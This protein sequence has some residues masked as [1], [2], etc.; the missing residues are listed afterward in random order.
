MAADWPGYTHCHSRAVV[1]SSVLRAHGP[2]TNWLPGYGQHV[3][4]TLIQ[5]PLLKSI[6]LL[7]AAKEEFVVKLGW[8]VHPILVS[9]H[10]RHAPKARSNLLVHLMQVL[11][12]YNASNFILMMYLR[13]S[14]MSCS[15]Q[16]LHCQAILA[17]PN[18]LML[19]D[20]AHLVHYVYQ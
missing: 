20:A 13:C 9:V 6:W 18:Q 10:N 2:Q 8:T 4:L 12:L 17:E 7:G 19:I 16:L 3:S 5:T 15:S 1:T 11:P 14:L